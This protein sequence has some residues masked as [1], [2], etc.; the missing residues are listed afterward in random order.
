MMN[1][2]KKHTRYIITLM[3]ILLLVFVILTISFHSSIALVKKQLESSGFESVK[4]TAESSKNIINYSETMIDMAGSAVS[5]IIDRGKENDYIE[6]YITRFSQYMSDYTN[7]SCNDIYGY[8]NGEFISSF[9]QYPEN[10]KKN[11]EWYQQAIDSDDNIVFIL[12]DDKNYITVSK[13]INDTD[14][15]AID[16][17]ASVLIDFMDESI[18]NEAEWFITDNKEHAVIQGSPDITMSE[19]VIKRGYVSHD[20]PN[21][22]ESGI[23]KCYID[24][25]KKYAFFQKMNSSWYLFEVVD[26]SVFYR[27]SYKLL[28]YQTFF[29]AII[30]VIIIVL[31]TNAYHNN[32]QAREA[33]ETKAN[34]LM[35]M[36]HEIRT[37]MNI[38]IGETEVVKISQSKEEMIRHLENLDSATHYLRMLINDIL[39]MSKIDS[40]KMELQSNAFS[41]DN[42]LNDMES[43]FKSQA[44]K[45][46]IVLNI[47]NN[48]IHNNVYGDELHLKQVLVNL[49]SNAVKFTEK[50]SI[51]VIAETVK[52]NKYSDIIKFSVKDTGIGIKPENLKRIFKPF[53]QAE[54]DISRNFGGTGLGLAISSSLVQMMN[55]KLEVVSEVNKGSEFTFSIDFCISSE[56]E[57]KDVQT[58]E[59]Q[60]NSDFKDRRVM[61][62]EDNELSAE[63]GKIMLENSGFQVDIA[64]NGLEAVE[65]FDKSQFCYY[66]IILMDMRMPVMNGVEATK[67][68]RSLRRKDSKSV[69]I[70]ALTAN[71]F[72]ENKTEAFRAGVNDYV[73]KPVNRDTINKVIYK[74]LQEKNADNI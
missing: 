13:L 38:I 59:I 11:L 48:C 46:N 18:M 70:I 17:D 19:V 3:A 35:N 68:I 7:Y 64:R 23:L 67:A 26:E 39:D 65:M 74:I 54:I 14:V 15:I 29:S 4:S 63:I 43:T 60:M 6:A 8:I 57:L 16:F 47:N 2:I 5:N 10:K 22:E 42:M 55:G 37:P 66:D 21:T 24:G 69:I 52:Q 56:Q 71:A 72:Q 31:Y 30:C 32:L 45:K 9:E 49:I 44:G 34:F 51:T 1:L 62:A 25:D 58:S 50:G 28:K 12:S 36:S 41:I 27:E 40:G 53:E 20:I 33:A 73:S 61:L